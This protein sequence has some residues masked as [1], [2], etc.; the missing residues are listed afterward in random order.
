MF[1]FFKKRQSTATADDLEKSVSRA[2]EDVKQRWRQFHE[3]VHL[4]EGTTLA[5]KIDLFAQ[6]IQQFIQSNYPVVSNGPTE[7]FWLIVFT[8]ILESGTHPTEEVNSAIATLQTKYAK[9]FGGTP[10]QSTGDANEPTPRQR[11]RAPISAILPSFLPV[12]I[13]RGVPGYESARISLT[14]ERR[15]TRSQI[16]ALLAATA[17]LGALEHARNL[18]FDT[19]RVQENL[20]RT[21]L[22]VPDLTDDERKHSLHLIDQFF[23]CKVIRADHSFDDWLCEVWW[24][25]F[26]TIPYTYPSA[27]AGAVAYGLGIRQ[28]LNNCIL[29]Y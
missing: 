13:E 14:G 25:E 18:N 20:T 5:T 10:S 24:P 19:T 12:L 22:E 4:K 29:E 27:M 15:L 16:R 28:S 2:Q 17:Y 9:S 21:L 23:N 1:E 11:L 8:A 6:P 3:A 26:Q 7:V